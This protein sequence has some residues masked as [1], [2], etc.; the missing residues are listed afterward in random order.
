[1]IGCLLGDGAAHAL[2]CGNKGDVLN[3]E[4]KLAKLLQLKHRTGTRLN[5]SLLENVRT[6]GPDK[7]S[8]RSPACAS[9]DRR[10]YT[11]GAYCLPGRPAPTHH[12]TPGMTGSR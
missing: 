7:L 12:R 9:A 1:M 10:Q 8:L 6:N 5:R 11:R 2:T 3:G 4:P